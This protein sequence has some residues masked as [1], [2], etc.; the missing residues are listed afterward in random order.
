MYTAFGSPHMA[1]MTIESSQNAGQ[2]M[3]PPMVRLAVSASPGEAKY[4]CLAGAGLSKDAGLPT[5][6]DLMLE[7]AAFLKAGEP[8]SSESDVEAW[9]LSSRFKDMSYTELIGGMFASSVEQ[10]NFIRDKLRADKP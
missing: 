7:T 9:F 8:E 6:W 2:I 10:Q 5:A 3:L 1:S 4:V